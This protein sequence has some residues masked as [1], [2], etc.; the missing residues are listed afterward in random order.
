MTN[1]N[2]L[3]AIDIRIN[4]LKT[5]GESMNANII[6]KIYLF[7]IFD[8]TIVITFDFIIFLSTLLN[9]K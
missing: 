1:A 9:P 8:F 6:H 4:L 3:K 7:N 2:K 5:R